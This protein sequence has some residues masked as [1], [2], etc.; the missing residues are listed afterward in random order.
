MIEVVERTDLEFSAPNLGD[1]R[2]SESF[3]V[4]EPA[5]KILDSAQRISRLALSFL[6]PKFHPA[7]LRI[8]LET[9]GVM[10]FEDGTK[11]SIPLSLMT[12]QQ[13][14]AK[15][16]IRM[17]MLELENDV[18]AFETILAHEL[19]HM[20]VEW[21]CRQSRV[22]KDEDFVL[23][24]WEKSIYE[25]VADWFAAVVTGQTTIGSSEIW[26]SRDI[27]RFGSLQEAREAPKMLLV[28]LE[29]GLNSLGLIEK[30][31]AYAEWM[32]LV[33]EYISDIHDPYAEGTWVA[34]QLWKISQ[35]TKDAHSLARR[36]VEL[37]LSGQSMADPEEFISFLRVRN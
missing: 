15:S 11:E 14:P 10:T 18:T 29:R 22:T 36:I 24:H 26:F 5:S 19:G 17:G 16:E 2:S 12:S 37:A 1:A 23:T 8:V 31:R 34:G 4:R 3:A 33:R 9:R 21:P 35:G 28:D 7:S 25:G 27:L 13:Q 20:L 30:Y 32:S 6:D